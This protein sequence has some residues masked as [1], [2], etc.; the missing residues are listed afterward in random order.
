MNNDLIYAPFVEDIAQELEKKYVLPEDIMQVLQMEPVVW[1][2]YQIFFES[3]KR[4]Q[5][6][7]IEAARKRPDEFITLLVKRSKDCSFQD[8]VALTNIIKL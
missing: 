5:I 7:Y 1:S 8:M 4:I 6:S 2:N 3:Y